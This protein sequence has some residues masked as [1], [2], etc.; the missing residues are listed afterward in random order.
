MSPEP[1][2]TTFIIWRDV[3]QAPPPILDCIE[4]GYCL[5]LKIISPSFA[6]QNHRSTE[7]HNDFVV[8]AICELLE[9]HCIVRVDQKPSMCSPLLV[10]SN[11]EGKLILVLN[12]RNLNQ[13][14]HIVKFKHEDLHIAALLIE[15][16]EYLFKL[17]LKSRY[18]HVDIHQEHFRFQWEDKGRYCYY[19]FV[20]LPLHTCS[21]S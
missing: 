9:N 15:T 21:Q 10:V 17:D 6:H 8:G 4:H 14:M 12:L 16:H 2:K 13:F 3:L 20:V 19:V 5:P 1:F 11:S 18:R 7:L